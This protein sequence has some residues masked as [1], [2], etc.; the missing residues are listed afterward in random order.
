MK[1][2]AL[3]LFSGGLDSRLALK[4]IQEQLGYKNTEAL[5]V[6]LPFS[7]SCSSALD[8]IREFCKK[9]KTKLHVLDATKGKLFREYIGIIVNPEFQRG[10]SVNP[11]IDCHIFLLNQ[12]KKLISKMEN[13]NTRYIL[14]TGEVLGERPLSQNKRALGII[15]KNSGLK[16]KILRPLSAKNL[17]ETDYEK[18]GEIIRKKLL[19]IHGRKRQ[20][21]IKLAKKFKI[22]Y[23]HPAGGC[24][25]CDKRYGEKLKPLLKKNLTYRQ[26]KLLSIG[27]HF[28]NSGIILGKNKEQNKI[29]EK[30]RKKPEILLVPLQP[31][32]TALVKNN[33]LIPKAEKLV[34]KY[35]KNKTTEFKIK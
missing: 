30:A 17:P 25:L 9:H 16:G 29:L 6:V 35:S 8:S 13:K 18:S 26:I 22:S 19:D 1:T 20:I 34:K 4:I 10:K 23:P 31:G 28:E 21:Q 14:A 15:E 2:K 7:G 24:L 5:T 32:P 3:V 27:R 11:C 33:K 12:A